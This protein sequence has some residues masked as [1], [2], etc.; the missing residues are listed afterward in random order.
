MP[1]PRRRGEYKKKGQQSGT[2]EAEAEPGLELRRIRSDGGP[3]EA[4]PD[5][6]N[7]EPEPEWEPLLRSARGWQGWRDGGLWWAAQRKRRQS[8]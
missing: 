4:E 7:P 6:P 3:E 2:R 8:W 1:A 5:E